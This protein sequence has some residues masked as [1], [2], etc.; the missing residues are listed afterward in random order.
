MTGRKPKLTRELNQRICEFLRAGNYAEV[1]CAS[2]GVG[3]TTFYR[4]LEEAETRGGLFREFRDAVLAASAEAEME[5]VTIIRS[6]KTPEH[7]KW[8]LERRFPER[9]GRKE[10]HEPPGDTFGKASSEQPVVNIIL[11]G[12]PHP[13]RPI[14]DETGE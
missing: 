7:A 11:E 4:W 8:F 2:V 10:R 3:T 6:V 5:A 12:A 9:W 13:H 1:A 14:V